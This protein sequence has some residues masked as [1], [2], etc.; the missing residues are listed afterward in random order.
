MTSTHTKEYYH[1]RIVQ[2][3][4]EAMAEFNQT[5]SKEIGLL[6]SNLAE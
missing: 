3:N 1:A 4:V 5:Y 2:Y 6:L